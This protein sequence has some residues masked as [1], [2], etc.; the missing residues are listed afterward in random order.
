MNNDRSDDWCWNSGPRYGLDELDERPSTW[1]T[2]SASYY[3]M[4]EDDEVDVWEPR[5]EIAQA[6]WSIT[7]PS[8]D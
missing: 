7:M 5:V 6:L 3:D 2:G 4:A 1:A 8:S